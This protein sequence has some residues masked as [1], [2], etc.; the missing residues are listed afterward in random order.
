MAKTKQSKSR[1]TS[2]QYV[3]DPAAAKGWMELFMEI[4]K[5]QFLDNCLNKDKE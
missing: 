5:K 1:I 2:I 4:T 3:H